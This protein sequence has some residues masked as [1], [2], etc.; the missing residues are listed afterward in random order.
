MQYFLNALLCS[1]LFSL[2]FIVTSNNARLRVAFIIKNVSSFEDFFFIFDEDLHI[3][4]QRT[5]NADVISRSREGN[6]VHTVHLWQ[7]SGNRPNKPKLPTE[8]KN[9]SSSSSS[10]RKKR[11]SPSVNSPPQRIRFTSRKNKTIESKIVQPPPASI[12]P[13][14]QQQQQHQEFH[15]G[16]A[17][18][19]L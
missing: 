7:P 10:I 19:F 18:K 14:V 16:I 6:A 5:T 9:K 13:A 15:D 11:I 1:P 17:C 12:V 8:K 4:F 2:Q 3:Y